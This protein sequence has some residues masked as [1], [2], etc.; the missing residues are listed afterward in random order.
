MLQKEE[1]DWLGLS[2]VEAENK[3]LIAEEQERLDSV[4]PLK[5]VYMEQLVDAIKGARDVTLCM[6]ISQLLIC[7]LCFTAG[8]IK[9]EELPG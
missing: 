7:R 2:L 8:E 9:E 6:F 5:H 1:I 3:L 4:R